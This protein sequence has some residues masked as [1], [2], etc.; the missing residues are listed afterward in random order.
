M[1][2]MLARLGAKPKKTPSSPLVPKASVPTNDYHYTRQSRNDIGGAAS[3]CVAAAS[4]AW[5]YCLRSRRASSVFRH[6]TQQ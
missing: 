2:R 3:I 4:I 6:S 5:Q 1:F